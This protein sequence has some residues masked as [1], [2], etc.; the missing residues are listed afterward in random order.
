MM[1]IVRREIAFVQRLQSPF[2]V[3][4]IDYELFSDRQLDVYMEYCEGG[5]LMPLLGQHKDIDLRYVTAPP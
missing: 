4:L 3:A 2:I 1:N 5:D